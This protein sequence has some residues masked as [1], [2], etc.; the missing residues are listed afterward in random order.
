MDADVLGL[1]H[2]LKAAR[3]STTDDVYSG[4]TDGFPVSVGMLDAIWMPLLKEHD[5]AILT[6]DARQRFRDTE[7]EAIR[8]NSLGIFARP[9]VYHLIRSGGLTRVL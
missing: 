2:V 1:Y 8:S 4:L 5:L 3:R 6:K 7:C 9:F